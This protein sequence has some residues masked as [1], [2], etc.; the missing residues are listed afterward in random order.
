MPPAT[1]QLLFDWWWLA[2]ILNIGKEGDIDLEDQQSDT[3]LTSRL[4]YGTGMRINAALKVLAEKRQKR[5]QRKAE[6]R[7]NQSTYTWL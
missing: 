4:K 1:I 3:V 6:V 5:Q 2:D 7:S